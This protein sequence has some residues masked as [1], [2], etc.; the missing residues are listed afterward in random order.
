M[1]AEVGNGFRVVIWVELLFLLSGQEKQKE[2]E[3]GNWTAAL[4]AWWEGEVRAEVQRR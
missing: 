1:A 2:E 4:V 3:F